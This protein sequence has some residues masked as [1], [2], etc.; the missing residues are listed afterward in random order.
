MRINIKTGN[1]NDLKLSCPNFI[2]LSPLSALTATFKMNRKL[3]KK[4]SRSRIK[5][6]TMAKM[7]RIIRRRKKQGENI[8]S[9]SIGEDVK[10]TI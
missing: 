9:V 2:A 3:R 6:R 1:G 7:F 4:G 8:V 10:I 5:V